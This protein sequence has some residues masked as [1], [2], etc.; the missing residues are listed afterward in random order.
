MLEFFDPILPKPV[1]TRKQ[2]VVYK[3][4]IIPFELL[5]VAESS[6]VHR[7]FLQETLL[8]ISEMEKHLSDYEKLLSKNHL[9]LIQLRKLSDDQQERSNISSSKTLAASKQ[10]L[11]S[12]IKEL[13]RLT[14]H[15]QDQMTIIR[16]RLRRYT[17]FKNRLHVI[18]AKQ[19][20]T[21][22]VVKLGETEEMKDILLLS[23][24]GKRATY[25]YIEEERRKDLEHLQ[26][27]EKD[28]GGYLK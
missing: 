5:F 17:D 9:T 1:T 8:K 26:A 15:L 18:E 12:R 16:E 2:A 14:L 24:Q 19:K 11:E 21:K 20:P 7:D 22:V 3:K 13:E 27:K 25:T 23:G 6:R 4:G 10:S 28:K